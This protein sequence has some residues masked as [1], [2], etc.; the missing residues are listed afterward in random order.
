MEA[1]PHHARGDGGRGILLGGQLVTMVGGPRLTRRRPGTHLEEAMRVGS[2]PPPPPAPAL[3][4]PPPPPP[5]AVDTAALAMMLR[6]VRLRQEE[7]KKE[8]CSICHS[9]LRYTRPNGMATRLLPC[10]HPFHIECIRRWLL[11]RGDC[12]MC[13]TVSFRQKPEMESV[14]GGKKGG[15]GGGTRRWWEGWQGK[16]KKEEGG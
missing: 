1:N 11:L 7:W 16:M 12:P 8:M 10:G 13:R 5:A 6:P 3:R 14:G 4:I 15:P 2:W 9:F